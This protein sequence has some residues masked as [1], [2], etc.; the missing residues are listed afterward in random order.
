[1]QNIDRTLFPSKQI[2]GILRI[3]DCELMHQREAGKIEFVKKGN[4]FLYLL[5]TDQSVLNH[6]LGEALLNW[7]HHKHQSTIPNVPQ[8]AASKMALEKLIVD[9][10]L[11]LQQKFKQLKITYGFTSLE[12]KKHISRN[13][14]KGTAPELDQHSCFELNDNGKMIC[15]RGGA[16][17]D[18]LIEQY[19]M[20]EV[21]KYI[22]NNLLFDRLYF[23]GSNRPIH[24]S[25]NDEPLRH[26]QL[27]NVSASGRR[28]PGKKAKG[29]DS[30]RLIGEL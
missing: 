21:V 1:M 23:Y 30:I 10:L 26:L 12:L 25:I 22:V 6:F 29:E 17:C 16:A 13:S 9:I 7:H 20:T 28:H 8:S 19:S 11:P 18:F 5:P 3:S 15:S 24:I 2:K 4:S 14:P 27:M